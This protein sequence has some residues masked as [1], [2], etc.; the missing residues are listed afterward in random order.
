[1]K[2]T[3]PLVSADGADVFRP[4]GKWEDSPNTGGHYFTANVQETKDRRNTMWNQAIVVTSVSG[5]H[6]DVSFEGIKVVDIHKSG[7]DTYAR[8]KARGKNYPLVLDG[9]RWVLYVK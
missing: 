5:I 3:R 2:G 4:V 6:D 8:F 7:I 9:K 1:M